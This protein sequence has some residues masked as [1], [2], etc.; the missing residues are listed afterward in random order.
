MDLNLAKEIIY[1]EAKFVSESNYF[2]ESTIDFMGGEP[3]LN[4]PLTKDVV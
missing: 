2:D 4:F 1:R 3:F